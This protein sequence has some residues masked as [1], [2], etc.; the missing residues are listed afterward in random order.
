MGAH[1][2][3]RSL[4]ALVL[5]FDFMDNSAEALVVMQATVS[6][7]LVAVTTRVTGTAHDLA[8]LDSYCA[9]NCN[10]GVSLVEMRETASV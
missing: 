8:K 5:F 9:A 7:V 4:N 2:L 3:L 1:L 10:I 6:L